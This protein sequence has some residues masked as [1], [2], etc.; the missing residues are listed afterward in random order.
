MLNTNEITLLVDLLAELEISVEQYLFCMMVKDNRT[1]EMYKYTEKV[2][3][4]LP[5]DLDDLE[6]KGYINC[7]DKSSRTFDTYNIE[8]K[9]VSLVQNLDPVQP[10]EELWDAYPTFIKVGDNNRT[11]AK[12]YNKDK[13]IKEYFMKHGMHK[14]KHAMIM[15]LTKYA[16]NKGM[17]NCGIQRYLEEERWLAIKDDYKRS[18]AVLPSQRKV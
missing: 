13:F 4:F 6:E 7:Y 11:V 17:I 14:N 8:E 9:F 12:N 15:E 2:K 5:K 10:G 1:A 18:N 16:R 3:Y